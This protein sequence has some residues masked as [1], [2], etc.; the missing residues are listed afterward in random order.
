MT[1]I[2]R[3]TC[4]PTGK[5]YIGQAVAIKTRWGDHKR[6]LRKGTHYNPG[7]QEAYNTYGMDNLA[8]EIIETCKKEQLNEKERFYVKYFGSFKNGFNETEGGTNYL[9]ENNPMYGVKGK[10]APRFFDFILQLDLQ[11]NI[12]QKFESSIEAARTITGNPKNTSGIL[13]CLYTWRGKKYNGRRAFTYYGYQWIYEGDY[14]KLLP[15][16]DFSHAGK[17]GQKEYITVK[18]ADKGALDSDIQMKSHEMLG[19]LSKDNQQPS[20]QIKRK[21]QRLSLKL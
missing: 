2:Y 11:G 9:G 14:Y 20:L 16:H 7:L 15:Y 3:I 12:L 19:H 1:G 13:K 17:W 4:I 10:D 8:F 18:L 5:C 21:A 6:E